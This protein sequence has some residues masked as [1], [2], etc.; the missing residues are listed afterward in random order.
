MHAYFERKGPPFRYSFFDEGLAMVYG[1]GWPV[2]A[3]RTSLD[4]AMMFD[5]RMPGAHY[6]RAG[7][8]VSFMID[9]FGLQATAAFVA[10][11]SSVTPDS[12]AADF[13]AH[14]GEPLERVVEAY[15]E[16]S[17]GCRGNGWQ[18]SSACDQPATEW[19][20]TFQWDVEV[21]SGC[22][23]E[24][25]LGAV[26]GPVRERFTYEPT[27]MWSFVSRGLESSRLGQK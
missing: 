4:E 25:S 27:R 17:E 20:T 15:S 10:E 14:F 9:E 2:P 7:H 22:S 23:S 21:G 6:A 12:L 13:E 8:F 3:P 24:A 5:R 19:R 11:S 1:T 26:A 16:Q 18:R